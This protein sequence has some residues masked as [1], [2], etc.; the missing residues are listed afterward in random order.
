MS[1]QP[2]IALF[3]MD[4]SI[5]DYE[6]A[7]LEALE[8][9]RSPKENKILCGLHSLEQV[10]YYGKRIRLIKSQSGWWRNLPR[11]EMGFTILNLAREIGFDIHILT[12]GPRSTPNA[13]KEKLEWCDNQP[14][15]QGCPV[16]IV[17]Q[18]DLTYGHILYDDFP[19]YLNSWLEVRPRGQ[20]IMPVSPANVGY[21]HPNLT[22]WN[23]TPE[24]LSVI[25]ELLT[26]V[27]HREPG[28][29]L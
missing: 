10:P 8:S 6:L 9:L 25:K 1:N 2:K 12:K 13:W 28:Q 22:K 3:D 15:L 17:S 4:G 26:K 24:N 7:M 14:E 23:G 11:I 29:E 27:F 19:D 18:K 20:A 16:H 21:D 5:A